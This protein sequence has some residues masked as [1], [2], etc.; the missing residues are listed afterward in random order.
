MVVVGYL[1]A[2]LPACDTMC[3]LNKCIA[4]RTLLPLS[5]VRVQAVGSHQAVVAAQPLLL[6]HGPAAAGGADPCGR[7]ASSPGQTAR[8]NCTIIPV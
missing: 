4:Q 7:I 5:L 1:P 3:I 6:D 2:N 8:P